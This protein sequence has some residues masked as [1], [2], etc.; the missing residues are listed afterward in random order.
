MLQTPEAAIVTDPFI[1]AD[2]RHGDRYTLDDLPDHIDLVLITHGHQD[3]IVLETLLQL[4]GRVGAVVV[5]RSSRGNLCDPS[6][7]ALP[8]ARWASR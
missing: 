8:E 1:S 7:G 5:P 4:R 2:N 3:H 6:I